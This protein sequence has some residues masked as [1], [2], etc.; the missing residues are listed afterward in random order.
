[1]SCT[2]KSLF[3]FEIGFS[4]DTSSFLYIFVQHLKMRRRENSPFDALHR[5]DPMDTAL[6]MVGFRL[7]W[8]QVE[9]LTAEQKQTMHSSRGF[10]NRVLSSCERRSDGKRVPHEEL[11]KVILCR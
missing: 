1:M 9:L 6:L 3:I 11:H 7:A 4:V 5:V 8:E 2:W 10:Q